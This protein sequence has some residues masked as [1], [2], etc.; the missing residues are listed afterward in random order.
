M[1]LALA[2]G[3]QKSVSEQQREAEEARR[4]A[5]EKTARTIEETREKVD[6]ARYEANKELADTHD[7][8]QEKTNE[9]VA[10][11]NDAINK[12]QENAAKEETDVT[13]ALKKAGDDM[14]RSVETRLDD[15]DQRLNK[16]RESTAKQSGAVKAKSESM[17]T[18]LKHKS[19]GVRQ[20][21][22]SFEVKTVLAVDDFTKQINQRLNE[23]KKG[24]DQI[25]AEH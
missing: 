18:D 2:S 20:D 15:I 7:K 10:S 25:E 17:L 23:L 4:E 19:D 5:D 13:L 8:L 9:A 1:V 3:C 16:A 22:K 11:G 6:Q 24:I 21:L 12:A 14:R